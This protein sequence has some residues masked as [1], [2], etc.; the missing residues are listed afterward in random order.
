[1]NFD[2]NSSAYP[3]L[4][5]LAATLAIYI[6]F[7]GLNK[8][9]NAAKI[10]S[11]QKK[12]LQRNFPLI[13]LLVWLIF[14]AWTIDFFFDKNDLF[15]GALII[16]FVI[17]L[18]WLAKFAIKEL[19]AGFIFRSTS[20]FYLNDTIQLEKIAGK[21]IGMGYQKLEL[22][23]ENGNLI[24][25]PYSQIIENTRKKTA[26]ENLSMS[27]SFT[28][29]IIPEKNLNKSLKKIEEQII[30]SPFSALNKWPI[31]EVINKKANNTYQLR[32]TV[33]ALN[34]DYFHLIKEDI[35]QK[36]S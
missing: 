23:D 7:R 19:I 28:L 6:F 15:A 12:F 21:I 33:H 36:Y 31:I 10:T 24:Q 32:I 30:N 22:E 14:L 26:S 16:I 34:S 4:L 2:I 3:V 18:F 27:Q 11:K 9:S 13:E 29:E 25:I 8:F 35:S 1:M 20:G 5:F 17:G